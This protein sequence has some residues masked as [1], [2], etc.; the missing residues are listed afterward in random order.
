MSPF[1]TVSALDGSCILA[2]DEDATFKTVHSLK[3]AIQDRRGAIGFFQLRLLLGDRILDDNTP[4]AALGSPPLRISL[5]TLPY[6]E[7]RDREWDLEDAIENRMW[8]ATR[9]L[10]QLPVNP[11]IRVGGAMLRS[12]PL[13]IASRHPD[14]DLVKILCFARADVNAVDSEGDAALTVAVR[15]QHPDVVRELVAAGANLDHAARQKNND[16]GNTV[17]QKAARNIRSNTPARSESRR[18]PSRRRWIHAVGCICVDS[19]RR[20]GDAHAH[21]SPGRRGRREASRACTG[22]G[23]SCM[24]SAVA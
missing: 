5:V 1:L 16:L 15:Q 4:L 22:T 20:T 3:L 23:A 19:R 24:C 8:E 10:L 18:Q 6:E 7:R 21:R 9:R 11:N 14:A 13:H 17:L 2:A 12:T